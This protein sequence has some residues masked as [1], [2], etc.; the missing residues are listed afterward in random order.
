MY[1]KISKKELILPEI[2]MLEE[3]RMFFLILQCKFINNNFINHTALKNPL[4]IV[5]FLLLC[6]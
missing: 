3:C 6:E 5:A 4:I 2:K 1:T